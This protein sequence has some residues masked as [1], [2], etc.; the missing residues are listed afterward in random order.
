MSE[1]RAG[2]SPMPARLRKIVTGNPPGRHRRLRALTITTVPAAMALAGVIPFLAHGH[3]SPARPAS[4]ASQI[5]CGSWAKCDARGYDSYG[6]GSHEFTA[7]WRM[8]AGDEC[9]NYAAFVESTVYHVREPSYLLG[10]GGQ[11][12]YSAASHGALVNH[13]PAVGAVAE[14]DGGT[15][16]MGS[17]G[18]VGVVEEV[19]PHDSWIVVSQQHMGG[20]YDYNWTRIQAQ[21]SA[22]LW[23]QWPTHFIHFPIP[24]RADVGY[25]N[26]GTRRVGLRASQ[27]PGPVSYWGQI[28][29][30]GAIPLSGNWTGTGTDRMGYYSPQYGIFH[31]LGAGSGKQPNLEATFDR[32]HQ[33]PLVGDWKGTGRDG[34]GSY[35]PATGTFYLRQSLKGGPVDEKFSYGRPGM[36]PLAGD[37]S[38]DGRDGVGY[39]NPKTGIFNLRVTLSHGPNWVSFRF[40]PPHMIPIAGN[41][42]GIGS[43]DGV[44]YYDRRTGTFYLRDRLSTGPG[45][46]VVRFGPLRMVP[47][48]GE[49]FGS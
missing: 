33:V 42:A 21:N 27:T 47:L 4:T 44:G 6:Y 10:N 43:K 30:K 15:S 46:T 31:L 37:W 49:W 24:R 48:A 40:G 26:P 13:I 1:D 41:W 22:N 17:F 8:A 45:S 20:A 34:I 9:T 23:Q 32:P 28:P 16:G 39:Y 2:R 11:W 19:G 29:L 35:D 18:H 5:V 7:Y 36:I 25:F 38:G 12:A 14:W 3:P